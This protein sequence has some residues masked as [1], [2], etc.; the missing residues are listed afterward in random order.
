MQIV[1]MNYAYDAGDAT[2]DALLQR[3][4]S[5]T[6]WAESLL[7]AGAARVTV[8][9][10]Y[11][12]DAELARNGVRYLFRADRRQPGMR[13][14]SGARRINRVAAE[15]R[16]DLVHVNGLLYP[17]PTCQLRG[18][19]P[20]SAAIVVQD[21]GGVPGAG[22]RALKAR[23]RRLAERAGLRAA[24]AFLFTTGEQAWP[25]RTA[26][27]IAPHQPVFEVIEG[28]RQIVRMP[29]ELARA[30]SGLR[31]DP[32]LLWVG[33]LNANKDPLTVL[34]GFE[35]VLAALP[36]AR[37]AMAYQTDELLPEVQ[38][39]LAR[40]PALA[41]RVDLLGRWPHQRMAELLSAADLFVLGSHREGSGYAL[42]EALACGAVPLVT[43]I[44]SFRAITD[45]G[46]LGQLWPPGDAATLARALL[47]LARRDLA[48]TRA[49]MAA[50]FE[51]VLSWPA[52]GRRA[53]AAYHEVL[54]RR[55][56]RGVAA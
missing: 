17:L 36:A 25:W 5:L 40:A 24:D 43:D 10:R 30:R 3:Y 55:R 49:A 39:R 47:V 28:S 14:W 20:R 19:L 45:G 46:R 31:G 38:A 13:L 41:A 37:L 22:A 1:L 34:D 16:P 7:V 42:I 32:A 8:V 4:E 50:H 11:A 27:L 53:L 33:R 52:I 6:G 44:P 29:R 12:R 35:R 23:V 26:G 21:H 15:L 2:L 9:Q 51:R 54:A 18:V 48:P 56:S